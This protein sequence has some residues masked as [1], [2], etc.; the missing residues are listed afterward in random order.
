MKMK[1]CKTVEEVFIHYNKQLVRVSEA[2]TAQSDLN[3]Q[4]INSNKVIRKHLVEHESRLF[5]L[6]QMLKQAS[7]DD[8]PLH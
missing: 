7:N 1:E 2:L 3:K 6:E 4:L 8:Q 5:A